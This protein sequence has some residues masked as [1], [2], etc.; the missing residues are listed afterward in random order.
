[1]TSFNKIYFARNQD[2]LAYWDFEPTLKEALK[3]HW[4]GDFVTA[5]NNYAEVSTATI[6]DTDIREVIEADRLLLSIKMRT[7][8]SDESPKFR[9]KSAQLIARYAISHKFFFIDQKVSMGEILHAGLIALKMGYF[10]FLVAVFFLI[11]HLLAN[12]GKGWIGFPMATLAWNY[13]VSRASKGRPLD[14]FATDSIYACY[15]S[16]LLSSGRLNHIQNIVHNAPLYP[17]Q[18]P[19]FAAV[20]QASALYSFAYSGDV[21]NTQLV[22]LRLAQTQQGK[23]G[24][25]YAPISRI[26]M[27]LP[28]A[29]RGYGYLLDERLDEALR[30]HN[31][32]NVDPLIN[33]QFFRAVAVIFLQKSEVKRAAE[34]ITEAMKYCEGRNAFKSWHE[35]DRAVLAM[36]NLGADKRHFSLSKNR[37]VR[38]LQLSTSSTQKFQLGGFLVGMI[39]VLTECLSANLSVEVFHARVAKLA[40]THFGEDFKIANLPVATVE[41]RTVLKIGA[42]YINASV[43]HAGPQVAEMASEISVFVQ[44]F[45]KLIAHVKSMNGEL[46]RASSAIAIAKTTQMLAHDVRK[47]FSILRMGLGMLTAAKDP[48]DVKALLTRLV[49][50]IDHAVTSVD[51]LI[52]DVMEVGSPASQLQCERIS[53]QRLITSALSD[54][55]QMDSKANINFGYEL[56]SPLS[57]S[58][59][60]AKVSRVF[61][62]IVG[63]AAQAMNKTGSMW[64]KTRSKDG[65]VEFCIGNSGSYI[66]PENLP[67]LFEAFFTSG[68]KGGTGLGLAIA[69]KIVKEHGGKIWCE[70]TKNAEFPLGKV[71]F[72]FTLPAADS[73]EAEPMKTLPQHSHELVQ[74]LMMPKHKLAE[75][76][77]SRIEG[78]DAILER[79]IAQASQALNRSLNVLVVDDEALYRSA[80]TTILSRNT[81]LSEAITVSE[82][83]NSD[84]ALEILGTQSFDLIIMDIDLGPDSINGFELIDTIRKDQTTDAI[85]CVHSNR[86][87]WDDHKTAIKC[88]ADAFMPKPM[89]RGQL[90]RLV[91]QTAERVKAKVDAKHEILVIDDDTIV[92][93]AWSYVLG[94]DC[95]VHTL[96]NFEA[97]AERV[98]KEPRFLDRLTCVVTDMIFDNSELDGIRVGRFLKHKKAKLPV[99]LSSNGDFSDN[100]IKDSIDRVI[101]KNPV[102]LKELLVSVHGIKEGNSGHLH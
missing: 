86:V 23:M 2:A 44:I 63:N 76:Q 60:V 102:N 74:S 53:P 4:R 46:S 14:G 58:V 41:T 73:V 15:P 33:S 22:A 71:E 3:A 89:A 79:D 96:E 11:G 24:L 42:N 31:V 56:K 32:A 19:Y 59:N 101:C 77:Q 34:Y 17:K 87:V 45:E 8:F 80:L 92:R 95:T 81:D 93:D 39:N 26:M 43:S 91:L 51:G 82:A 55:F 52:A 16:T 25:R 28:I 85:I 83:K 49:P 10:D 78:E 7:A 94:E 67:K 48:T 6:L 72:F 75:M 37:L 54:V 61:T 40:M 1:M 62:N 90:L 84:E 12:A 65:S 21:A 69:E 20:Y 99:L 100:E 88:G 30:D 18:D 47:P 38:N 29:M 57:V 27:L 35:F 50:A 36:T 66:A 5:W 64:F 70:S 68:K 97:L 13:A 9:E 98:A